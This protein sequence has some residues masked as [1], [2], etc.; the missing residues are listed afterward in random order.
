M[1]KLFSIQ[2]VGF[3]FKPLP[4]VTLYLIRGFQ[5]PSLV[6]QQS[7]DGMFHL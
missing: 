3:V 7:A 1:Q 6:I 4:A 5:S 2:I